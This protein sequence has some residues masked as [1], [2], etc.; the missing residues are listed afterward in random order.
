MSR[1]G[2][3]SRSASVSNSR[4]ASRS[5]SKTKSSRDQDPKSRSRSPSADTPRNV[6]QIQQDEATKDQRTI[7][8]SQL[9]MKANESDI[10][11]YFRKKLGFK[12]N[13]V[14]LLKDKRSGRHKGCAYVELARLE[15]VVPSLAANGKIPDFQ[16]FPILLK[17]SESEKN[18]PIVTSGQRV[19]AQKVYVGNVDQNVTQSQLYAIFSQFGQLD[20]VLLQVD[21]ATGM[22][23]GFAF[24]S[25]Q[26]AKV[27]NLSIVAMSGQLLAGKP[28]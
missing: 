12:V 5:K 16:R 1:S 25:Y 17:A 7:F 23:K 22:S 24:L 15:D 2:S 28:M 18:A 13:D 20:R 6:E 10:R 8:V 9:V 26:D 4:S 27:S 11:R 21:I 3:R 14:I 19:E